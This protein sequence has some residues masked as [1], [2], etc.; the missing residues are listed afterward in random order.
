MKLC[1]EKRTIQADPVSGLKT[2]VPQGVRSFSTGKVGV[3]NMTAGTSGPA[4]GVCMIFILDTADL[5]DIARACE[6]FPI[7]GVTTNPS[8][9]AKEKCDV[10]QRLLEIRGIIGEDRMLCVQTT[11]K[12]AGNIVEEARALRGLLGDNFY[13]KVPVGEEGLKATMQLK[14]ERIGVL[15]T[16]VF[17][18][19]QALLSARA[20]AA[21]VAPYVNRLDMAN[22]NGARVVA[23]IVRIFDQCGTDCRVL[24]ASFKNV[25]QVA[26]V[27]LAGCHYATVSP[28][29]L[30]ALAAHPLTDLAV[31]GF[32]RDWQSVY[33]DQTIMELI[34]GN[35]KK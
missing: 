32:D 19:M 5:E 27:A 28:E 10:R 22:G 29:I 25:Q 14:R 23:D 16:A 2:I 11:A 4:E 34:E 35:G 8:I 24:A 33:G 15:M 3:K 6:Y 26:S 17:T 1:P 12:A 9:I 18:P 30:S 21:L 20:G 13:I 31:Q 7:E